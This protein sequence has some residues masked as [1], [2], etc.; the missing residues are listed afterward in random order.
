MLS[1]HIPLLAIPFIVGWLANATAQV[2]HLLS[3][4]GRVTAGGTPF[5]GTGQFKFA[6]VA[7]H[8][9]TTLWSNDGAAEPMAAVA[10]SV[11]NGLFT[12]MLGDTAL[13]NM[14]A[15]PATAFAQSDLRL[16]VWFNDGVNGFCQLVPDQRLAAAAYAITAEN[17]PD[18]SITLAKLAADVHTTLSAGAVPRAS[19][20]MSYD[21]AATNLL[22]AGFI[23]LA[24]QMPQAEWS[25]NFLE[26][27]FNFGTTPTETTNLWAGGEVWFWRWGTASRGSG[28][29]YQP[30]LNRW[31]LLNTNGAPA[32][33]SMSATAT[34]MGGEFLIIGGTMEGVRGARYHPTLNTWTP[35]AT[36]GAPFITAQP[37]CHW[38][39]SE[40]IV[41]SA[42]AA[43]SC[44]GR[45][46]PALDQW[47]PMSTNGLSAMDFL[48]AKLLGLD[49]GILLFGYSPNGWQ[50]A[51][52]R[53]AANSWSAINSN[54]PLPGASTFREVWTGTDWLLLST[55]PEG[56]AGARY[57]SATDTW[58]AISTNGAPLV[59]A[60]SRVVW[61]GSEVVVMTFG[62]PPIP[63]AI[64][65][66]RYSPATDQW[67]PVSRFGPS[68]TDPPTPDVFCMGSEL[69][70]VRGG[71]PSKW[72][73][74]APATDRWTLLNGPTLGY[75]ARL[76]WTGTQLLSFVLA[77]PLGQEAMVYQYSPGAPL[78]LYQKP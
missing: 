44:V 48:T 13:S 24:A 55:T 74:Y 77:P 68:F 5:N 54:A 17:V 3:Y 60:D 69:L 63:E 7:G 70:V 37:R 75:D 8:D 71:E 78:Y 36:N 19:V 45:Y 11:S 30:G 66:A 15:L 1:K 33:D 53:S 26:T 28:V 50:G 2:P 41:L 10:L 73:K 39:G 59:Q 12:V 9:A 64:M 62:F 21:P 57:R 6:L 20:V 51:R 61:T 18:G 22:N 46:H 49:D 42:G 76:V 23:K 38:T 34:W 56:F 32:L 16:R 43:E 31:V 29:R 4:Q 52:Y 35:L 65:A 27:T 40:L 67:Q 14:S 47:L 25:Q 72:A 58:S